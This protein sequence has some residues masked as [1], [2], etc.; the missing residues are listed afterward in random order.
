VLTLDLIP[1]LGD[2]PGVVAAGLEVGEG[3]HNRAVVDAGD[4][5]QELDDDTLAEP[6]LAG[7][8]APD[9]GEVMVCQIF[10]A[11]RQ[12]VRRLESLIHEPTDTVRFADPISEPRVFP[13]TGFQRVLVAAARV[14]SS[15]DALTARLSKPS[16]PFSFFRPS[17]VRAAQG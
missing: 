2:N 9:L 15:H 13:D 1:D 5:G 17:S 12:S 14:R 3:L 8:V 11:G 10:P 4:A 6:L 7:E 16:I